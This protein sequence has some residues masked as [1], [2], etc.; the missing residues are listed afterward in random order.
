ME[1]R[2]VLWLCSWYP[3][4]IQTQNGDFIQR[5]ARATAQY[6]DVCTFHLLSD[7]SFSSGCHEEWVRKERG[8]GLQENWI[9]FKK[10][11]G[12]LGRVVATVRY[13]LIYQKYIKWYIQ[14]YGLPDI[15][16][17]NIAMRDGIVAW[18]IKKKYHV[19]YVVTE[20]W[21]MYHAAD[22]SEYEKRHRL[23]KYC[24]KKIFQS[25]AIFLPVTAELGRIVNEK[26][27][28]VSY[29]VIPNVV[30]ITKFAQ[31]SFSGNGAFTFIHISSF[32]PFKN[33]DA[34]QRTFQKLRKS[35]PDI[36]LILV[37]ACASELSGKDIDGIFYTGVIEY[38]SVATYL[39]QSNVF[40]LFSSTENLPCVILE[41]FVAGVP[42]IS[43]KVGG[44]ADVID[45]ENGVLVKPG[46]EGQL[47]AAMRDMY[48]N[49]QRYDR[50]K[51]A[52]DAIAR[53][54]YGAVGRQIA[55]IYEEVLQSY[56]TSQ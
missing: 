36:R 21:N 10:K 28:P 13:F 35:I 14:S 32:S 37:G 6:A 17:V 45:A 50:K 40:V 39:K 19:P 47:Y 27:C 18:W 25:T 56:A 30:D 34:I 20:H 41:S 26:I 51:I 43:T 9:Y 23:F 55:D 31:G 15:V 11:K 12:F 33:V 48:D 53:Y 52:A 8:E 44:I 16:H 1:K 5:Q 7:I 46:E 29:R 49:Y 2:K 24:L 22:G 54:S 3:D 42:V 38:E 4:R